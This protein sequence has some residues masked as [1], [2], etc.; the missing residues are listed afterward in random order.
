MDTNTVDSVP[1]VT[2]NSRM[3]WDRNNAASGGTGSQK[4]SPQMG[5]RQSFSKIGRSR[6]NFPNNP[7]LRALDRLNYWVFRR[8]NRAKA[9]RNGPRGYARFRSELFEVNGPENTNERVN[10]ALIVTN[11]DAAPA[12]EAQPIVQAGRLDAWSLPTQ[13][14]TNL[15]NIKKEKKSAEVAPSKKSAASNSSSTQLKTSLPNIKKEQKS[16]EVA[17]S[18]ESAESNSSSPRS[19]DA[20]F[21]EGE[22]RVKSDK[23]YRTNEVAPTRKINSSKITASEEEDVVCIG[24]LNRNFTLDSDSE[25]DVEDVYEELEVNNGISNPK[26]AQQCI[27]C[28]K[29]GHSSF[30][31]QMI[32]K[33]CSAP[34]HCMKN[35]PN[36]PNLNIA[37]QNFM[38][39]SMKQFC[40]FNKDLCHLMSPTAKSKMQMHSN[41]KVKQK[42]KAK[43]EKSDEDE[44]S[45]EAESSEANSS[46][47][48]HLKRKRNEKQSNAQSAEKIFKQ[49][50]P[51]PLFAT[52][53]HYNPM[54]YPYGMRNYQT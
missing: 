18:K 51:F 34:Y 27:I 13:L 49:T 47:E 16:T 32:C 26:T 53:A 52:G 2:S 39:F 14:Q 10:P 11:R 48:I 25:D 3:Q 29:K 30:E 31:C 23:L 4:D 9:T 1:I 33:N 44:D 50:F 43:A 6:Y 37:L 19:S 12:V 46:D 21:E 42:S 5:D 17:P 8:H 54:I 41:S 38:E 45:S 24:N 7:R 36:P 40:S 35:C 20:S 15:P 22:L 28:D